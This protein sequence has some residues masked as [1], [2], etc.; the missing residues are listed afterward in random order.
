MF[1]L[2]ISIISIALVALLAVATI[3][4]GGDVATNASDAARKDRIAAQGAQIH[5]AALLYYNDKQ[6]LPASVEV[7]ASEGYLNS[8][9]FIPVGESSWLIKNGFAYKAETVMDR[10]A[11][12]NYNK[13]FSIS[14][15]PYCTDTSVAGQLALCCQFDPTAS[16][17]AGAAAPVPVSE[18]TITGNTFPVTPVGQTSYLTVPIQNTGTIPL[19][20][21]NPVISGAAGMTLTQT[22]CGVAGILGPGESCTMQVKFSPTAAGTQTGTLQVGTSATNGTLVTTLTGPAS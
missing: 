2:I 4:Y 17:A 9:P 7:L 20:V 1:A 16:T 12:L 6:A 22:K 8:V 14:Y 13:Q 5:G 15:V 19:F 3:Y 18:A 10:E 11:C 21:Q